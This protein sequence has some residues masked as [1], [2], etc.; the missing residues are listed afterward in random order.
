MSHDI[1]TNLKEE[2]IESLEEIWVCTYCYTQNEGPE[3]NNACC[4]EIH[5][6]EVYFDPRDGEVILQDE[7]EAWVQARFEELAESEKPSYPLA[8]IENLE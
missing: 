3:G 2:I 1:N 6:E 7:L 8:P 5:S 4:G